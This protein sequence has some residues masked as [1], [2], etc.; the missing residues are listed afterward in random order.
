M[1]V[2]QLFVGTGLNLGGSLVDRGSLVGSRGRRVGSFTRVGNISNV[3]GSGVSNGVGDSLD[4]AVRKVDRVGSAG[5]ITISVLTSVE[6]RARVVIGDGVVVGIDG[7]SNGLGGSVSV[8]GGRS[9]SRGYGD[10]GGS[11]SKGKHF[12]VVWGVVGC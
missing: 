4:S 2:Q 12:C 5:G 1:P 7:G 10:E 11:E 6:P 9:S 3:T 8:G